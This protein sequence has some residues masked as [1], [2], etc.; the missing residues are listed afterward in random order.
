VAQISGMKNKAVE[1]LSTAYRSM[2]DRFAF[3]YGKE[4]AEECLNRLHALLSSYSIELEGS[5]EQMGWSEEDVLLITYGDSVLKE[6]LENQKLKALEDFLNEYLRDSITS[7]HILPFFPF[8][9]DGGFAVIDY[10]K[11][12]ED[13]GSWEDI[14][15]LSEN[16]HLMADLVINH[17]STGSEWFQNF[18]KGVAPGKDYFLDVD[19]DTEI[20]SVTRPR[21]SPLLTE[22]GSNNGKHYLWTTFSEDQADLDFSNP[23]VLFEFIEIFLFY[24][25]KGIR[26]L[27]LDAIAYLWKKP[28]SSSIHLPE[29][30][31]IVK[32]FRDIVDYVNPSV[33]LVTETNVPF[34]EN[35]SYF[36]DGDEAHMIYQFSLPPLLLHAILTENPAY[37]RE[38]AADLPETPEGGTFL[39]FTSSHDGIGV[40]PL[41]GLVPDEEFEQLIEETKERGGLVSYKA[42]T[43][44]SESPYE[45]N[46][47]YFD[48]F[49]DPR[50]GSSELQYQRYMCSQLIMMSLHGLPAFY[51]HNFTGTR[52]NV[53][54]VLESQVKRDINRKQWKY[55]ELVEHLQDEQDMTHRVLY[56]LKEVINIRKRHPAFAP[57]AAQKVLSD[58]DHL[59][60]FVRS[61]DDQDERILVVCNVTGSRQ[62]LHREEI[63]D[64][65]ESGTS[66][67]ELI[68][69]KV[70]KH[71]E[72]IKL[73]PYQVLW[74][75][76]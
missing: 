12:R 62:K 55:S 44:G 58:I 24:L 46:I 39:N 9:S 2:Y 5:R 60:A 59:F 8:S 13:L 4:Q 74:L 67:K 57:H 29:T 66:F 72:P 33:S 1:K 37:L 32:L 49:S 6:G 11:V 53:E 15:R 20:S 3:I 68:T 42:N 51:I 30:H 10:R 76:L 31:E 61:S 54:G 40:R 36:G 41:E 71:G 25:S 73:D 69:G 56:R 18:K 19:P 43:D 23:D 26:I 16:Y 38:W 64:I 48:A 28:G 27:R 22:V 7:L 50:N 45:L 63:G 65:V 21:S 70:F 35:I 52:N 47:T 17:I 14:E 34:E 75:Q